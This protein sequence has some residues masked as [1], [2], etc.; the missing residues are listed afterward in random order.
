MHQVAKYMMKR[1][2]DER[3]AQIVI[4]S[5][6]SDARP[7]P[8]DCTFSSKKVQVCRDVSKDW[9]LQ[10]LL[11]PAGPDENTRSLAVS[12]ADRSDGACVVMTG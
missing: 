7:M 11:K 12:L 8:C 5:G 2:D 9:V 4:R 1:L 10:A 3:G 6:Q